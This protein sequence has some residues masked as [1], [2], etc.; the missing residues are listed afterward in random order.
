[1]PLVKEKR[2]ASGLMLARYYLPHTELGKADTT[3]EVPLVT[4]PANA[5]V[6]SVTVDLKTDFT[7]AG[8]I[9]S[10]TLQVGSSAD[11]NSFLTALEVMSGS[12]ANVR[13]EQRG[14]W[15]SG[16]GL[17]VRCL[18]TATGANFG[19]GSATDLDGGA[20]EIDV[21]YFVAE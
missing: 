12:P 10:V 1:M 4:L 18:A 2:L 6:V 19:T 8:S 9:S 21:I 17:A 20:A 11:P 7:D 16:D 13:Y 15:Q 5:C 3:Q 14:A